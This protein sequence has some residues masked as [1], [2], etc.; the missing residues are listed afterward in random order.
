MSIPIGIELWTV[1]TDVNKDMKAALTRVAGLGYD[2]VEF[3]STYLDWGLTYAL[4][5]REH[6]DDLGLACSSTHNGMR[7]FTREAF[8]KTVELNSILGSKLAVVASVPPIETLDGWREA[9]DKFADVAERLRPH[10]I[11][12]GFHNHQQE[13]TPIDGELPIEIVASRTPEDLVLQFDIGPAC[14]HGIDPVAW[15]NA[16]AGRVRSIHL[17]DWSATLGYN[18]AF[19]EGDCPW[20]DI[21]KAAETAGGVEMYLVENGHSTP[22]EEW[23]IAER[24]LA[25]FRRMQGLPAGATR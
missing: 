10:G 13:W 6:L 1:R 3:Y 2:A 21:L 22:E 19:G 16:H 4:E 25:N 20:K 5:I 8:D 23:G 12:A 9:A 11:A 7:A 15:I 24:S 17:R 18:I 14:Q